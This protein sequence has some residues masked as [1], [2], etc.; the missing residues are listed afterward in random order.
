MSPLE[1]RLKK[2]E[3]TKIDDDWVFELK[4]LAVFGMTREE[5]LA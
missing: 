1:R 3:G 5:A 4:L 2:L